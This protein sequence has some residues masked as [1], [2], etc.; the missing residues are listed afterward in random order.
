MF[1]LKIVTPNGIKENVQAK[2]VEFKTVEG[3]MGILTNRLPIVTK[4]KITSLKIVLEDGSNKIYAVHGGIL[5]MDGDNMII[6]TTD[7]E[8]PEEID[9]ETAIKAVEDAKELLK[10]END[11]L[12]KIKLMAKI[13]KNMLRVDISKK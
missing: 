4:L 2:Y 8:K 10:T 9:V 1:N 12:E 5:D 6:L 11:R 3:S 13:D 7:A